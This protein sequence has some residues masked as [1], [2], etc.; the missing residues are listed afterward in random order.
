[1]TSWGPWVNSA[2]GNGMRLGYEVEARSTA[3][4]STFWVSVY[5]QTRYPVTD[6]YNSFW[7]SG[8]PNLGERSVNIRHGGNGNVTFLGEWSTEVARRYGRATQTTWAAYLEGVR[9]VPGRAIVEA[10]WHTP[11]RQYEEPRPPKEPTATRTS[12]RSIRLGWALNADN[13]NTGSK[14]WEGI[15]V[16]RRD[17]VNPYTRL[18]TLPGLPTGYTDNTTRPGTRYAYAFRAYNS[19]G[20]SDWVYTG[21][22]ATSPTAATDVRATKATTDVALTWRNTADYITAIRI[23]EWVNGVKNT[24]PVATLTGAPESWEHIGAT[25][26]GVRTYTVEAVADGLTGAESAQSN[27]VVMLAK[28]A[29][30]VLTAPVSIAV[31]AARQITLAWQHAPTD[32]TD[33]TAGRARYRRTGTATWTTVDVGTDQAYTIPAGTLTNGAV[34]EWQ[35][36]TKGQHASFSDW[37]ETATFATSGTP[38]VTI[39]TPDGDVRSDKVTVT[40]GFLDPE[41][42]GQNAYRAH[43]IDAATG[44]TLRRATAITSRKTWA[45]DYRL[46]DKHRYTVR[47][48]VRDRDGLWSDPDER[49]FTVAYV[50]PPA[51]TV[52]ATW[53]PDD[54][55][56]IINLTAGTPATGEPAP[57]S[58]DL[59]RRAPGGEWETIAT[60]LDPSTT[61][62]DWTPP[63]GTDVE[64]RALTIS[65]LPSTHTG[66]PVSVSTRSTQAWIFLNHGP[67]YATMVRVGHA[68]AASDT[69]T[70]TGKHLVHYEG[71]PLPVEHYSDARTYAGQF[72]ATLLDGASSL[73]AIRALARKPGPVLL[74]TPY[75]ERR[76]VTILSVD[77]NHPVTATRVSVS[78]AAQQ[79]LEA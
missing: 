42:G 31:D 17:E 36:Q 28:P 14:P 21:W 79:E 40:W 20:E 6:M 46:E 35:A 47:V 12:D 26:T 64:Y 25:T 78:W 5:V 75:G 9:A 29:Q 24:T 45:P 54:G 51:T 16:H 34:Y 3:T 58:V 70:Y 67:E 63:V 7:M 38:T 68:P 52:V 30:P 53:D 57:V 48:W 37:S 2:S 41:G 23:Y 65:G 39:Q 27:P 73:A 44:E 22:I 15:I 18:V 49:T 56:V 71:M 59:Q 66:D 33:Q 60:G 69:E 32:G 43:L 19:A 55:V 77:A 8:Q 11:P 1:M 50:P 74:R 10:T 76:L 62:T 4:H 61:V 13:P 72:S